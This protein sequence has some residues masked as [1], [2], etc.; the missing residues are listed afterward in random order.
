MM[1]CRDDLTALT[2]FVT[3]DLNDKGGGAAGA[4]RRSLPD[5]ADMVQVYQVAIKQ[6]GDK[7]SDKTEESLK[8]VKKVRSGGDSGNGVLTPSRDDAQCLSDDVQSERD[9]MNLVQI[10]EEAAMSR[11]A[12]RTTSV[13]GGLV[14]HIISLWR[15]QYCKS[16]TTKFNCFFLMP[17][18]QEFQTFFRTELQ[19]M[20]DGDLCEA[21]DLRR[22]RTQLEEQRDQL[23]NECEANKRLQEKFDH[24]ERM[25][26]EQVSDASK[27]MGARDL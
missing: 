24:V 21:F 13:V 20:Y 1:R 19:G 23:L 5:N 17:F 27:N 3:W 9:Y 11:D 16:V 7:V 25:M 4:L 22:A 2:R 18:V 6:S 14:Q 8:T 12:N 10:I 26:Q 15:V